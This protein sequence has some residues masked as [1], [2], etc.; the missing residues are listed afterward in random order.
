[1]ARTAGDGLILLYFGLST[2]LH[3][4]LNCD[5]NLHRYLHQKGKTGAVRAINR[6]GKRGCMKT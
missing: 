6:G 2:A 4:V 5:I 1:M 3:L